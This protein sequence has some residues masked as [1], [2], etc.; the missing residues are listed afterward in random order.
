LLDCDHGFDRLYKG[1][2]FLVQLRIFLFEFSVFS[3]K[4]GC[5]GGVL[6]FELLLEFFELLLELFKGSDLLFEFF[7]LS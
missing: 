2:Y 4:L 1:I 3:R 7:I 6:F 5:F